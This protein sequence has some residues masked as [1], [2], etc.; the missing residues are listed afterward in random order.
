MLGDAPLHATAIS[1]EELLAAV[2]NHDAVGT[3]QFVVG[4]DA[5]GDIGSTYCLS[6]EFQYDY[7][8]SV[9]MQDGLVAT[10]GNGSV[11][12]A[13]ATAS[14]T[15]NDRFEILRDGELVGTRD[16]AGYGQRGSTYTFIDD[17]V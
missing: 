5:N 9:E 12:L 10:P 17:G 3:W 2:N 16:G 8:L 15:D 4:D 11:T 6:L 13:W 7:I 14:E 1:P